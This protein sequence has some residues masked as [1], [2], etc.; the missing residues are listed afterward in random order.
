VLYGVY[1]G[2]I[3]IT[4][5][6]RT[7]DG[8]EPGRATLEVQDVVQVTPGVVR[9]YLAGDIHSTR[10]LDPNGSVILR[11]LSADLDR[12]PRNRYDLARGTVIRT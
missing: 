6:R 3:E 7:D 8:G 4:T 10:A 9:P 1:Q 5:Y 11:F 2:A 12:V